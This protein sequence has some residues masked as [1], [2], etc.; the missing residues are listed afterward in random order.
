MKILAFTDT[1]SNITLIKNIIKKSKNI[2]LLICCGD[3]TMLGLKLEQILN[4]FE[5]NN[6]PLLIIPG[7]H[8]NP[9][10]LNKITSKLKFVKSLHSKIA[11][12][13]NYTFIGFGTGGFS[14]EDTNFENFYKKIKDKINKNEKIILVTHAPPSNTKLDLLPI[15]HVGSKSIRRFIEEFQPEIALSGHLHEHFKDEDK[16]KK[17]III[18]PGYGKII[19]LY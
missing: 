9:I 14:I 16:I 7:N 18:N 2:D 13:R 15:G 1:H 6:T 19:T 3:L 10:N 12:I 8:E 5:N 17:S 11:K 4:M